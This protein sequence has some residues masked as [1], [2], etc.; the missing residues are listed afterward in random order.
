MKVQKLID[1]LSEYSADAEV[2]IMHQP[3][4][5]LEST[6]GGVVGESEIREHEGGDL[7]DEPE[8][9]FLLEGTQ[10]GYGRKVAW[11]AAES[12]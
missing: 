1:L 2:R 10:L 9:V 4:Y 7:G 3:R 8:V 11:E 6:L 5:P 12:R